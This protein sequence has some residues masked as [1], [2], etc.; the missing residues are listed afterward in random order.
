MT[1]I[2]LMRIKLENTLMLM[3]M[4]IKMDKNADADVDLPWETAW[5]RVTRAR[6]MKANS[7]RTKDGRTLK[8]ILEDDD[9]DNG[10]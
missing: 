5:M 8:T 10:K 9:E 4:L 3:L 6:Q 1:L 2:L 7:P